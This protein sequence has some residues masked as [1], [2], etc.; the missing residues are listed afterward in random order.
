M[1]GS[2]CACGVAS[3]SLSRVAPPRAPRRG[4]FEAA[5][6][7]HHDLYFDDCTS[8]DDETVRRASSRRMR[9]IDINHHRF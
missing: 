8:P 2:A 3:S 6:I 7:R 9:H 1:S 5:G 4:E